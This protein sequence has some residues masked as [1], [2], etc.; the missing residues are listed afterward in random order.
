MK[1]KKSCDDALTRTIEWLLGYP[2]DAP[3][4]WRFSNWS[5]SRRR[6]ASPMS[7]YL[8]EVCRFSLDRGLGADL[9]GVDSEDP[10]QLLVRKVI[11]ANYLDELVYAALE[12]AVVTGEV[13]WA[14]KPDSEKYYRIYLYDS[15]EFTE[16]PDDSGL[17]GFMVQV[18]T[19]EGWKRWGYTDSAYI[20]YKTT[21]NLHNDW[22][23]EGQVPHG[24]GFVPAVRVLNRVKDHT[25]VGKPSFDWAS[26]EMA[27]EICSQILS[28][29]SNYSYFGGPLVVS[30]D[31]D[32]TLE[33]LMSRSQVV[34]GKMS[35]ELQDV[36]LLSVPAMPAT[37]A[38]FVANLYRNFCDHVGIAWVPDNP[39][40]A[41]GIASSI[42]L[43]ML[44]SKSINL[45]QRVGGSC[46]SGYLELLGKILL[47]GAF[48]GL[49]VGVTTTDPTTYQLEASYKFD[50]FPLTPLEKQQILGVVE[51]L[52]SLGVSTQHALKE[53]YPNLTTD[54]IEALLIGA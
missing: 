24:Y 51:Q 52:Q 41:G 32:Q 10:K 39:T 36:G 15:P 44:F 53:Y 18:K 4:N 40:G 38:D 19:Q 46:V 37:H 43:K 48:D 9:P 12:R 23:E 31:P 21:K 29:A 20:K 34:T 22:E 2:G 16:Y 3:N 35:Q 5:K 14:F 17:K 6:L 49:V 7:H 1:F 13:L 47:A 11:E 25:H 54:E 33:E 30:P 42:S 27:M 26:T 45:A 50:I 28:S 8:G